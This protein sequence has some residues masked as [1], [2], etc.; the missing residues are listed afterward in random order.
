M[1]EVFISEELVV[2]GWIHG[3]KAHLLGSSLAH[4][5]TGHAEVIAKLPPRLCIKC[6]DTGV[7]NRVWYLRTRALDAISLAKLARLHA[8]YAF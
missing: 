6:T 8:Y 3:P 4:S 2:S 1:E 5:S 7:H